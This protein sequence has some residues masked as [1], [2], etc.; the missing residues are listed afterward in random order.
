M[1]TPTAKTLNV[2][3][4]RRILFGAS[5]VVMSVVVFLVAVV[6]VDLYVHRKF[7]EIGGFNIWGYRGLTVGAKR[8]DERRV[9]VVGESTVMGYG[10]RWEEAFPAVLET[11]LNDRTVGRALPFTASVVNLGFH[12][13]GAHSY[14]YTLE[15]YAYLK[16]DLVVF[17]TGYADL[18][19]LQNFDTFNHSV[20]RRDSSV[21]RWTGYYPMLPIVMREKAFALRHNGRFDDAMEGEAALFRP[22]LTQ[23][24]AASALEAA[25]QLS[26]ALGRFM[27]SAREVSS[28]GFI[29]ADP[30]AIECGKYVGYCGELYL[31]IAAALAR[32]MH[33]LVV[34]Q[35]YIT[36]LHKEQ[37]ELV[38]EYVRRRFGGSDRVRVLSEGP[39]VAL[40]DVRM[41]KDG[42]HLTPEGN[43]VIA[44]DLVKAVRASLLDEPVAPPAQVAAPEAPVM[45]APQNRGT[46]ASA[47]RPAGEIRVGGVDGRAMAWVPSGTFLLGSP[48]SE[49]HRD[50]EERQHLI[51]VPSGFWL[52]V[53][54]VT[55]AAFQ[56]FVNAQPE[57]SQK[58]LSS[59]TFDG[60]YLRAW[61]GGQS[62]AGQDEHPVTDVPWLAAR[63]YCTWAGKRLPTESEWEY[64]AR[65]GTTSAYW[66][67]DRFD[68]TRAN[69]N[70]I[71]SEAVGQASR[72]NAWGLADMLGNVWEWTSSLYRPYPYRS[73][74]GREN[75][76]AAIGGRRVV[77]GGSF[78]IGPERLRSADRFKLNPRTASAY[79]GFRCAQN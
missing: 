34:T 51:D 48:P 28:A 44:A 57:W 41:T 15:D 43:R 31:G 22:N 42:M 14:R 49:A 5:A 40:R 33:V 53:H 37:E 62:A 60:K 9:I 56:R 71:G 65:A 78:A 20:G 6:I 72:V 69:Q 24:S 13:D 10:V 11:L 67:G 18:P 4:R 39:T 45:A 16:A 61:S 47:L 68:A 76:D 26:E 29:V 32:G 64:A 79:V 75:P 38:L 73:D 21:F 27:A 7:H 54:E 35:P 66:W 55:N 19:F 12:G 3:R 77:R 8:A 36:D 46:R 52:D 70:Q 58:R 25:S 74:D 50:L 63:A 30:A 59:Q 23:R 17:Y 2:S 1:L